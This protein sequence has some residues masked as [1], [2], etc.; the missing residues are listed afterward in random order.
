MKFCLNPLEIG[1]LVKLRVHQRGVASYG[2]NPL[3]IGSLVK[4]KNKGGRDGQDDKK[5]LNPLEIGSLV[6]LLQRNSK[7]VG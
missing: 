3:E 4:L 5:S 6:K 2:L 7:N 1:S